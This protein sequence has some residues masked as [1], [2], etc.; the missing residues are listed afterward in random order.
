MEP[1]QL[2]GADCQNSTGPFILHASI[3]VGRCVKLS[4]HGLPDT[5]RGTCDHDHLLGILRNNLM[6]EACCD[7]S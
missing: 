6:A 3:A 2:L 7:E 5:W 1:V 4:T